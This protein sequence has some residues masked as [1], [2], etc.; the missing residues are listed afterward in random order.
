MAEPIT[1][2][3]RGRRDDLD[4]F[5]L[6]LFQSEREIRA[7][8]F[9]FELGEPTGDQ[10]AGVQFPANAD[11]VL[12]VI[13]KLRGLSPAQEAGAQP[14]PSEEGGHQAPEAAGA[15]PAASSAASNSDSG[16][17]YR[18]EA[19]HHQVGDYSVIHCVGHL[20][21]DTT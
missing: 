11:P 6:I 19:P 8:T 17:G 15:S 10:G 18:D 12:N 21:K 9:Q 7:R 14:Q 13:Y 1:S 20:T 3:V 5:N 2:Q 4:I 16:I